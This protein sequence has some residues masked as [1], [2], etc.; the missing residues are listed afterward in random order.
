MW[1]WGQQQAGGVVVAARRTCRLADRLRGLA[2]AV[3]CVVTQGERKCGGAPW[4]GWGVQSAIPR[5]TLTW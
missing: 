3:T 1:A 2:P 5:Y 4:T